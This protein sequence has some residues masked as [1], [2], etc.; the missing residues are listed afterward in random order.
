MPDDPVREL[1][2]PR[3]R[4]FDLS[5]LRSKSYSVS[6]WPQMFANAGAFRTGAAHDEGLSLAACPRTKSVIACGVPNCRNALPEAGPYWALS[7]ITTQYFND[8]VVTFQRNCNILCTINLGFFNALCDIPY[9]SLKLLL[10]T[11]HNNLGVFRHNHG[12]CG[13]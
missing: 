12:C 9:M 1:A 11:V 4:H 6:G 13:A 5:R 7:S 2:D 8:E 3:P 10:E